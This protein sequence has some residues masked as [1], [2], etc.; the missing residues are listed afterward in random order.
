MLKKSTTEGALKSQEDTEQTWPEPAQPQ[1]ESMSDGWVKMHRC[2]LNK[3]VWKCS[4][5]EQKV[6]LV[7]VLLMASHRDNQW[8]WKGEKFTVKPGQFITSLQSIADAS[9]QG[10]SIKN[11]RTALEKFEKLEFLA[12]QTAK[13]GRLITITNWHTYQS[14]NDDTGKQDGKGVAKDR[15]RGGKG[16]ATIKKDKNERMEEERDYSASGDAVSG[17]GS[18]PFFLT[19]KERK[20]KG[21]R[22]EAFNRFWE[23]FAYKRGKAEAADA[24]MDIPTLTDATVEQICKAAEV[25]AANRQNVITGGHTPKMAQGWISGRRWEDEDLLTA[26]PFAAFLAG[27]VR[28]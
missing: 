20:L 27:E 6:I 16:V 17:N 5:P 8:I 9:G 10:I 12:S 7:T 28:Q 25:E 11:V 3:A 13:S 19:R 21:K 24:W 23:C 4:T 14:Q 2:L 22:L 15:Q 26:D 18:E 1:D